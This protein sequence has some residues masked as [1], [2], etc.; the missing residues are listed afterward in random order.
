LVRDVI[1]DGELRTIEYEIPEIEP[2]TFEARLGR[3]SDNECLVIVRNVTKRVEAERALK[4]SEERARIVS[5]L[6]SDFI[7]AFRFDED[8]EPLL[9]WAT[10]SFEKIFGTMPEGRMKYLD[11]AR[12]LAPGQEEKLRVRRERLARGETVSDEFEVITADG[13][14][15]TAVFYASPTHDSKTGERTGFVGAAQ[16]ITK[17][18]Q[19]ERELRENE[20]KFLEAMKIAGRIVYEYDFTTDRSEYGGAV[21]QYLERA[22]GQATPVTREDFIKALH[23]EDAKELEEM[24]ARIL[25]GERRF[26]VAYRVRRADGYYARVRDVC[27]VL[28]DDAEKPAKLFG[29]VDVLEEKVEG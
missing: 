28:Y 11:F 27:T 10:G 17:L 16:D 1:D 26:D 4:R 24:W 22:P 6:I 14:R 25:E 5:D 8:G 23:P 20:R 13:E 21:Y 2:G 12:W 29:V 19:T 3:V 7:Y 15:K 18:R 9:E